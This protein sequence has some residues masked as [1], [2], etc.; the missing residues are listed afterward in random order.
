M[1]FKLQPVFKEKSGVVIKSTLI[2]N[3]IVQ[4]KQAKLGALVAIN[5]VLLSLKT[6]H[7]LA[8]PFASYILINHHFLAIT[9]EMSFPYLLKSLMHVMT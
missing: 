7:S 4:I 6:D 9:R 1:I 5:M 2:I 3:M 8:K